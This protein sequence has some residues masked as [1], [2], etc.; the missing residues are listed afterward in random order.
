MRSSRLRTC[1]TTATAPV[2]VFPDDDGGFGLSNVRAGAGHR[3]S[4]PYTSFRSAFAYQNCMYTTAAKLVEARTGQSW[5]ENL[6]DNIFKPLGMTRSVTTQDAV[7]KMDNVAIGHLHL[8]NGTLWPIPPN[9]FWNPPGPGVGRGSRSRYRPSM[10]QWLR[11]HLALGKLGTQQIVTED[12]MRFLHSPK[13][14][15]DTLAAQHRLAVLGPRGLLP[16]RLAVLGPVA[17]TVSLS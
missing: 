12:N 3:F 9:W 15:E 13:I 11:F 4:Q 14:L 2:Y 10:G 6:Y 8:E 5:G 16:R 7:N 17:P 1:C